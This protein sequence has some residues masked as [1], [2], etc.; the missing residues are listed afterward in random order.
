MRDRHLTCRFIALVAL[1]GCIV[2]AGFGQE[3]RVST[4]LRFIKEDG[5]PL[6]S[7]TA[8]QIRAKIG[9]GLAKTISLTPNSKPSLLLLIDNSSS[10]KGMW[11][12]LISAAKQLANA[13]GDDVAAVVFRERILA[14]ANGSLETAKLLDGLPAMIPQPGGTT[15]YDTLIEVAGHITSRNSA[16]CMRLSTHN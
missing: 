3:C 5:K 6:T 13:A 9:G 12:E 10:I 7:V 1:I 4:T 15:V 2:P 11:N 8:D 14:A 16:T